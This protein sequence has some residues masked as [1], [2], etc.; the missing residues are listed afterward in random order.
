M[1]L[2]PIDADDTSS[3]APVTLTGIDIPGGRR[4]H[5]LEALRLNRKMLHDPQPGA[6]V[7]EAAVRQTIDRLLDR[8][9]DVS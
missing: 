7:D 9:D 8:L 1:P 3:D 4:K 5:L 6:T 2:L